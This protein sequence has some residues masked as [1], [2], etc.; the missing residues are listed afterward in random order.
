VETRREVAA[1]EVAALVQITHQL[2][3]WLDRQILAVEA[4]EQ[5]VVLLLRL[6]EVLV[7]QVVLA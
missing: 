6:Q 2:Q 7:A 3:E 4:A 5:V 1:L